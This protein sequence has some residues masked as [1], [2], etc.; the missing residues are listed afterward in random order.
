MPTK[1]DVPL[2]TAWKNALKMVFANPKR[3]AAEIRGARR[4]FPHFTLAFGVVLGALGDLDRRLWIAA[5]LG[6]RGHDIPLPEP[7]GGALAALC[8]TFGFKN[9]CRCKEGD[10]QACIDWIEE[11][12]GT[13]SPVAIEVGGQFRQV[14]D[15]DTLRSRYETALACVCGFDVRARHTRAEMTEFETC[16]QG[17]EAAWQELLARGCVDVYAYI[18]AT[19]GLIARIG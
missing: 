5:E 10:V 13:D 18:Q 1:R 11:S 6:K 17:L 7:P 9:W 16:R 3:L 2:D 4:R 14:P 8:E 12:G 19:K 15:C